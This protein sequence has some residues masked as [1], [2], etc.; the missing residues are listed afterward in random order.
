MKIYQEVSAHEDLRGTLGEKYLMLFF[1]GAVPTTVAELPFAENSSFQELL[2]ASE[3]GSEIHHT[4]VNGDH[5]VS[6]FDHEF[7]CHLPGVY[8]VDTIVSDHYNMIPKITFGGVDH[9]RE[10]IADSQR[11]TNIRIGAGGSTGYS[12]EFTFKE[13]VSITKLH[14]TYSE[15]RAY[16]PACDFQVWDEAGEQWVT[17]KSFARYDLSDNPGEIHDFA[18]AYSS[19]RYRCIATDNATTN[20]YIP[21]FNMYTAVQPSEA[22]NQELTWAVLAPM[23]PSGNAKDYP[24]LWAEVGGPN[25]GLD[26]AIQNKTPD[27]LQ[28]I[29]VMNFKLSVNTLGDIK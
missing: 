3:A 10:T 14:N 27:P 25:D 16:Q 12:V 5:L 7:V 17:L 29:V 23:I 18:N 13:A 6:K 11:A 24:I 4:W 2:A 19:K 26:V 1:K 22:N 28:G 9:S 20:S 21:R 8:H 15:N